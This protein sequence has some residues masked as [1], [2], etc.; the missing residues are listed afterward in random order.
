MS[1]FFCDGSLPVYLKP[2]TVPHFCQLLC[3]NQLYWTFK[4]CNL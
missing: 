2:A 3:Q 1:L 4:G